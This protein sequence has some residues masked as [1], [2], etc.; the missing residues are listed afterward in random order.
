[1]TARFDAA[2]QAS[3]MPEFTNSATSLSVSTTAV[4]SSEFDE[5][6]AM[7]RVDGCDAYI[8][9]SDDGSAATNSYWK[10]LDG[11]VWPIRFS[12]NRYLSALSTGGTG[13]LRVV[14]VG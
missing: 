4:T 13:T 11:E 1:M 3:Y 6:I 10:I 5:S 2:V 12:K 8:R 7:I 9:Q 14:L